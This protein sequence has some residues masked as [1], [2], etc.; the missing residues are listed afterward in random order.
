MDHNFQ[1]VHPVHHFAYLNEVGIHLFQ[2][3]IY[4]YQQIIYTPHSQIITFL[5]FGYILIATKKF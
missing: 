1:T 3:Q 4:W 2:I 5:A